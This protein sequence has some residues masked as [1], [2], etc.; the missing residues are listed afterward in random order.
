LPTRRDAGIRESYQEGSMSF[1]GWLQATRTAR[2][3]TYSQKHL[4]ALAAD[5]DR[6]AP[7]ERARFSQA[8]ISEWEGADGRQVPRRPSL[9]QLA[10]LFL[11]LECTEDE[12]TAGRAAWEAEQLRGLPL[13]A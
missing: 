4:A 13:T 7:D 1:A 10:V 3:P 12:C 2:G 11:A 5:L 6:E 8:R 9:R